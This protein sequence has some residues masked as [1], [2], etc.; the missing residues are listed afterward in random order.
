MSIAETSTADLIWRAHQEHVRLLM[1]GKFDGA[2]SAESRIKAALQDMT[3]A[4]EKAIELVTLYGE[5]IMKLGEL[6]LPIQARV[7]IASVDTEK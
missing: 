3:E 1:E 5:A 7:I 4:T 2:A 6:D